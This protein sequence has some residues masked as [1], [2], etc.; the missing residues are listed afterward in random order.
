M[1]CVDV[2]YQ[3]Y[4]S[5]FPYQR[6]H[7]TYEYPQKKFRPDPLDTSSFALGTPSSSLATHLSHSLASVSTAALVT[8]KL[9]DTPHTHAHHTTGLSVSH[10]PQPHATRDDPEIKPKDTRYLS[11]NCV[12]LT[13][14]NGDIATNVD[15]HFTKALNQ[16]SS[17][18]PDNQ[19]SSPSSSNSPPHRPKDSTLMS[20]RNFPPSFWNSSYQPTP[21]PPPHD[22]IQFPTDS[23]MSSSLHGMT[24]S[25]HGDP[26]HYPL[27]SS[28][29]TYSRSMHDLASYS[30]MGSRSFNPHYGS[31]L[32]QP[33][34][35]TPR[36]GQC[37]LSKVSDA[38]G[39]RYGHT[40][41]SITDHLAHP[42]TQ[43]SLSAL[44]SS[45]TETSKDLY[46]F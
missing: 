4:T 32:M 14:F 11:A 22:P 30:S 5:Y 38:W 40:E 10:G 44:E 39:S 17:Y 23:Y 16:P 9:E 43:T 29:H 20:E 46:W 45:S 37:D 36:L 35:R 26:W 25:L 15:E 34:L 24:S 19:G 3:P 41:S 7:P 18:T 1:T 8:P 6:P 13:Y 21:V 12:L 31:L 33:S 2:M 28:S 27:G 42:H